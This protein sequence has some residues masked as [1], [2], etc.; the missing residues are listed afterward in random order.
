MRI[1][2]LKDFIKKQKYVRVAY[3]F[4]SFARGKEGPLS[5]V[6][7]A[8]LLDERLDK[9]KR[10]DLRLELITEIS[11]ILGIMEADKLD[12]I[13]MNDAPINLNQEIIKNGKVLVVKDLKKKIEFESKTLSKY[14]DRI[15]YDRRGLNEFL[16]KILRRGRL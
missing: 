13:V 7:I 14:L 4:G 16:D 6:D 15:Y 2:K 5:D 8:V 3:L 12:V 1:E 11:G 9:S 10:F